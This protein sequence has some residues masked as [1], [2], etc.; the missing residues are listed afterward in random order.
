MKFYSRPH[1]PSANMTLSL[2]HRAGD[3]GVAK[4]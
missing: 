1:C 4:D 2:E 3:V